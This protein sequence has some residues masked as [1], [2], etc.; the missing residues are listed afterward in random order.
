MVSPPTAENA[1]AEL[2]KLQRELE[3]LRQ[4][5]EAMHKAYGDKEVE[6]KA[7][8]RV[9]AV[10]QDKPLTA[11]LPVVPRIQAGTIQV[12]PG[13]LRPSIIEIEKASP[14]KPAAARIIRRLQADAAANPDQR[15]QELDKKLDRLLREVEELR[16]ELQRQKVPGALVPGR[17]TIFVPEDAVVPREVKPYLELRTESKPAAK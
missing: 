15:S 3:G 10:E 14:D 13:T 8:R 1:R 4:K 9:F 17:N 2:E 6:F 12:Q 16:R 5:I 11:P 7:A